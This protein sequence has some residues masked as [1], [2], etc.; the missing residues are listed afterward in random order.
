MKTTI[1]ISTETLERLKMLKRH[2]RE[3]HDETLNFLI[4]E[5]DEDELYPEEIEDIKVALEEVKRGKTIPFE[6]VLRERGI[7]L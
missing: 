7:K 5:S 6:K 2:A 4:D 1:Q 3:S